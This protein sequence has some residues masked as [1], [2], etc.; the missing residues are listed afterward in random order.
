MGFKGFQVGQ[1]MSKGVLD[2][3]LESLDF[4]NKFLSGD[5]GAGAGGTAEKAAELASIVAST[6]AS[7]ID[8]NDKNVK[9]PNGKQVIIKKRVSKKGS[10]DEVMDALKKQKESYGFNIN[11]LYAKLEV[12]R[13]KDKPKRTASSKD[14]YIPKNDVL[15]AEKWRPKSFFDLIGNEAI[16]RR[17][18]KWIK[19]WSRVVFEKNF[20][21][22]TTDDATASKFKDPFGRPS[23]KILLIHGPPGLGKTTVAHVLAKQAGYEIM[24]VNASDERSGQRVRDKINNSLNSQTFSGKPTCL[25]ADEVDGGA[26]FGFIKVLLDLIN[27]DSKAVYK[28]QNADNHKH[29]D[30]GKKKP[31]FLLRPVIAICNDLYAPALEKLRQHAE[32]V[33]F[34]APSERELRE[35]LRT[36]CKMENIDISNQQLQEIVLLTNQDIRS[37]LNLLQFGGGINN[38]NDLRKK[39]SQISWFA[40][41]NEIFR[42]R[43]DQKKSVQFKELSNIININTNYDKIINGCF[44]SYHDITYNDSGL[45]KPSL[46]SDWLY[47]GDIMGKTTYDSIGDLSYYSAQVALQFFNQFSDL[48][49]RETLMIKSD[50]E[51]CICVPVFARDYY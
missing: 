26:E 28:Y 33:S 15:W 38:S 1:E 5:G 4:G 21:P 9:L 22:I 18:L 42:R 40:V 41:V 2:F 14:S 17:I 23:K 7:S 48:A 34:R 51:V 29:H 16:N 13:L 44:Q 8:V 35:R 36:I 24:E 46:I 11:E 50:Y 45:S 19:E 30:K 39:D 12:Q 3:S 43:R 49:N 31:K 37:C 6:S 20:K 32:I 47:F 10:A 27:E 25:I